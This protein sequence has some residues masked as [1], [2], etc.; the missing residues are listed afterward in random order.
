MY[1]RQHKCTNLNA[2]T[3]HISLRSSAGYHSIRLLL[4]THAVKRTETQTHSS[5]PS[6][7]SVNS[8]LVLT[9]AWPLHAVCPNS[10]RNSSFKHHLHI[11][12]HT[13]HYEGIGLKK[14]RFT[15]HLA[16]CWAVV[17]CVCLLAFGILLLIHKCK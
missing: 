4:Q 12:T 10:Y 14:Q 11:S 17:M 15:I 8:E 13:P 1:R 3:I 16:E 7:I 6:Q 2:W 9:P 5:S